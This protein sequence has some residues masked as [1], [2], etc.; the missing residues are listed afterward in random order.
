MHSSYPRHEMA[1]LYRA[2]DIMVVTPLRDGMKNPLLALRALHADSLDVLRTLHPHAL[3][4]LFGAHIGQQLQTL[5][6]ALPAAWRAF[7]ERA[8]IDLNLM[9]P[10][11][12]LTEIST[13]VLERMGA[14]VGVKLE[15]PGFYPAGGGRI[16]VSIEPAEKLAGQH[17]EGR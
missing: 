13:R 8:D 2:A 11:Q 3:L 5:R 1:A 4:A 6:D 17:S 14:R 12:T 16:A 10:R 15:R 9:T 7:E